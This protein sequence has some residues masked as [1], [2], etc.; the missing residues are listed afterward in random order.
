MMYGYAII[1]LA[2]L[3]MIVFGSIAVTT[4]DD[5]QC[6]KA[7]RAIVFECKKIEE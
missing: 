1:G 4:P 6:T 5:T 3:V 2:A 7:E